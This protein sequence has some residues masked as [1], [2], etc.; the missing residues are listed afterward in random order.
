[1]LGSVVIVVVFRVVMVSVLGDLYLKGL[2]D[3]Q[4]MEDVVTMCLG[5][6]V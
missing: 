6:E 3:E 2:C 1:M 4:K 5:S